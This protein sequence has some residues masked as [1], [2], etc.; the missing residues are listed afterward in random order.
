VAVLAGLV[1]GAVAIAGAGRPSVPPAGPAA[2]AG[3]PRYYV[4]AS[5]DGQISVRSS[6]AFEAW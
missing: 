4:A 6:A 1:T 3:V 5:L 2:G